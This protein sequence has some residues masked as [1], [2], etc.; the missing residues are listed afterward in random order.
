MEIKVPT[1]IIDKQKVN[2]NIT[3][4]LGK[5]ESANVIFRPHFKTHQSTEIGELFKQKGVKR[6]TVS[7]VSMA[8]YFCKSWVG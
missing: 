3:R 8:L 4:M 6:I 2:R 7:S 5:A 1:L